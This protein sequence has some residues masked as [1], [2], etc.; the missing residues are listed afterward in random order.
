MVVCSDSW[1]EYIE[2]KLPFDVCPKANTKANRKL[3]RF[4]TQLSRGIEKARSS[5]VQKEFLLTVHFNQIKILKSFVEFLPQANTSFLKMRLQTL[6][7]QR[8]PSML[9]S[10]L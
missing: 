2:R 4:I 10:G 5:K 3:Q 6:M 7:R 9:S 1:N 8:L